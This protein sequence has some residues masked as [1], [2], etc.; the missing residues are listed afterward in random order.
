MGKKKSTKRKKLLGTNNKEIKIYR[1]RIVYE[2]N[3]LT[4]WFKKM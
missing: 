4:F 2:I 1:E 3:K